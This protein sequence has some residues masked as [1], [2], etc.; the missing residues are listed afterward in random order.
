MNKKM[1]YGYIRI[2]LSAIMWGAIPVFTKLLYAGG[3]LPLQA[4]AI[5]GYISGTI[6]LFMLLVS[7][8]WKKFRVRDIPFY[9]LYGVL[10]VGG[11][12]VLY[13]YSIKMNATAV[14]AILLYTGPAFVNILNRIF[15]G[16]K[17][18]GVKWLALLSTFLGCALV[19]KAYDF[20]SFQSNLPGILVGLASGFCYSIT[21]VMGEKA[22]EKYDGKMNARLMMLFG[23]LVFF[24]PEPPWKLPPLSTGLWLA[25]C[26]LAIV[27]S[28]LP[29]T[30]Y[31][32]ALDC[33]IDGGAAS[34]VA[35]FEPV[36]ATLFGIVF[37]QDTLE[38]LQAAGIVV[39]LA[40]VSLPILYERKACMGKE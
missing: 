40:G 29:Y 14:A 37:F 10:A 21:T 3:L 18:T 23:A 15:Y 6:V 24:L 33:G 22:K 20:Y 19:V 32:G 11:T 13:A 5:R 9:L 30:L 7:G 39:V 36:A 2:L 31:I 16:K 8:E 27:G 1:M 4:S 12:Y 34:I 35:T 28:I 17:I 25:G 38:I 26:G